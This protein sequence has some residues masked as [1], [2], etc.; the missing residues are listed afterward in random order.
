VTVTVGVPVLAAKAKPGNQALAL[1]C[2]GAFLVPFAGA[3]IVLLAIGFE[4]VWAGN[5]REGL[6]LC[7]GGVTFGGVALAMGTAVWIGRRKLADQERLQASHPTEPWLW[8]RDWG[9]GRIDD[10]NRTSLWTSW[11]F[12]VFWNL[13][14]IPSGYLGVIAAL[15]QK[16]PGG[17]VA[18]VFP[19]I[20]LGLLAW[21]L[22]G[23]LRLRK[24]GRSQ[25]ELSTIPAVIAHSLT[26]SLRISTANVSP[27]GFL[28]ML[29]CIRRITT[30]TGKDRTTTEKILW[31]D[32]HHVT[33]TT[34]RDAA[35][36]ATI[37]PLAFRVP[38]D[39]E[40]CR[41]S[42]PDDQILWRV[43][44]SASVPGVDY[45]SVFEVP[46]FRTA[47]S[48]TPPTDA[49]VQLAQRDARE[50]SE[51]RQPAGSR[52]RVSLSQAGVE[53]LFPAARNPGAAGAITAFTAAWVGITWALLHYRAPVIFP[54]L[55]GFFD[56]LLLWIS[57]QLWLG[58]SRVTVRSGALL[59]A[60][61]LAYPGRE[62][63]I[64]A[65]MITDVAPAIGMQAGS[66]PYYDVVV[67]RKDGA[68][69]IAGSS[70]RDKRE[71]EWLAITIEKAL[72]LP[73]SGSE[74]A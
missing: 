20:G 53:I 74:Q 37:L 46:V 70:V 71:A 52:I 66:T 55:F 62:Q 59:L 44:V 40:P 27:G 17:Y 33:G 3:G 6:A 58:V 45:G 30:G 43:S 25:L 19:V 72:G 64:A 60:K 36:W 63:K 41:S 31:Q 38:S 69:M 35:G 14:A 51:Y 18:L 32:D 9:S 1:G 61:G 2:M 48:D 39:A 15:E 28:V 10:S 12:A 11:A 8:R 34:T 57:L 54:L 29:S 73:P 23:T 5:W 4:R 50:L 13:I 49:E 47:A 22:R 65:E 26:G 68:K 21:A 56:L 42:D 16:N 67:R 24:Y 7:W